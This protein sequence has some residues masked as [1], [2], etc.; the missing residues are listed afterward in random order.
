MLG[1]LPALRWYMRSVHAPLL[2]RPAVKAV[3]LAFF[4]GLL[5]LG[6]AAAPRLQRRAGRVRLR[7]LEQ[8]LR[9]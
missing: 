5:L 8:P 2:R 7:W 9:A 3:V 6:C 1:V 4:A